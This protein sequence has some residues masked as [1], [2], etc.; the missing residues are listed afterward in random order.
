MKII[1]DA[2]G[3]DNAPLEIVKGAV[4][5]AKE[6]KIEIVLVGV[7]EEILK[8]I[9]HLGLKEL[10]KGVEVADATEIITMED[11]PANAV[12]RKPDSS[13][14]IGLKLLAED[15]GGA[16]VSAGSTGAL[17]TGSTLLV[18]RITGIRRA[19]MAPILPNGGDGVVLI[20]CG[21]NVE[22]TP[23]YLVQFAFMGSFYASQVLNRQSPRVGLLNI[24]TEPEKGTTLHRE[25]Y[26]LLTKAG[27]A[28]KLSFIGNVEAREALSGDVDVIVADGFSGNILLKAVEGT[29]IFVAGQMK[30]KIFLR[31]TLSKL[32][33]GM[34]QSGLKEFMEIMNPSEY[35]GT[36]LL[37][38]SK[39]VIKAHGNSDAYAIRSAIRQAMEFAASGIIKRIEEN[40][41]IIKTEKSREE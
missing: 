19:A 17:L 36:A 4:M 29:A 13:M 23:E 32:A 21:A 8:S 1:V 10:P 16:M 41:T 31:N 2:M 5:A 15:G 22:C 18:K 30:N 3:G 11:D 27:E 37:G 24:G 9:E 40:I 6:L 38:I 20:D 12:R 33:A 14:T 34:V 35:G 26:Q 25:A 39:P 7:V 28:G